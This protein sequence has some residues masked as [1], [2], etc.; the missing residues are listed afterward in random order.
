MIEQGTPTTGEGAPWRQPRRSLRHWWP[1]VTIS[2]LLHG[3]L[4]ASGFTSSNATNSDRPVLQVDRVVE[5]AVTPQVQQP[6]P[7]LPKPP[8]SQPKPKPKPPEPKPPPPP[9]PPPLPET[10]TLDEPEPE[11][12]PPEPI[13]VEVEPEPLVPQPAP[14]QVEPSPPPQHVFIPLHRLTRLPSFDRSI[15]PA[16]PPEERAMG[17]EATVVAQVALDAEGKV[18]EVE[19]LVSGGEPFDRAVR[20]AIA[21]MRFSPGMLEGR[22][23]A[24]KVQIP[25]RFQLR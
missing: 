21:T 12:L 20:G 24:V 7:P 3:L 15:A 22:P 25:F 8:T 16:Y 9:P 17:R 13:P 10:A 18:L 1:A 11:P 14:P 2:L 4:L 5:Q 23:V 19:I 6:P